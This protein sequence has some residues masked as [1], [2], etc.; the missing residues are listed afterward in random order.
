MPT[1]ARNEWAQ[2]PGQHRI[3]GIPLGTSWL[4]K[5]FTINGNGQVAAR[6]RVFQALTV[7]KGWCSA[8]AEE[9]LAGSDRGWR[10][11]LEVLEYARGG[12]EKKG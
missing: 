12:R 9:H 6:I 3:D 1:I 10:A 2:C 7:R 4:V 8:S 11:N 5:N